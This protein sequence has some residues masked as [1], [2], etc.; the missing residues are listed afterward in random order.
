MEKQTYV[1]RCIECGE[2]FVTEHQADRKCPKCKEKTK[3]KQNQQKRDEN[4]SPYIRT[5]YRRPK[6]SPE[7][8]PLTVD[9]YNRKHGTCLTYGQYSLKVRLGEIN[10]KR[11]GK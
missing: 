4:K 5:K 9:E 1:K 8:A 7:E 10:N 6:I 3:D 11:W 2:L